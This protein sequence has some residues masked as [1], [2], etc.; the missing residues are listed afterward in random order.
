[1][2][3]LDEALEA[4]PGVFTSVIHEQRAV[5]LT[6]LGRS[7]EAADSLRA[8]IGAL[9]TSGQ[10]GCQAPLD[11]AMLVTAE[12]LKECY[13]EALEVLQEFWQSTPLFPLT[14]FWQFASRALLRQGLGED[15]E[16][17]SDARLALA[18][19]RKTRAAARNHPTLGLVDERSS[20]LIRKM[21]E[22]VEA[23]IGSA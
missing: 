17:R 11:F 12:G 4:E 3:F 8:A 13:S 9:R 7:P 15:A 2:E 19:A 21:E 5:S 22:I 18:A 10:V 14:E 20:S 1:M 16:A 23:S 6:A